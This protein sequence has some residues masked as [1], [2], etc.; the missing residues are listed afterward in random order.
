LAFVFFSHLSQLGIICLRFTCAVI[1]ISTRARVFRAAIEELQRRGV[2]QIL[3]GGRSM[4]SRAALQA[5]LESKGNSALRG[6]SAILC[7]ISSFPRSS[8]FHPDAL[9]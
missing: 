3:I 4:G 5:A 1:Q 6:T 9:Y 2:T 8:S 7:Q